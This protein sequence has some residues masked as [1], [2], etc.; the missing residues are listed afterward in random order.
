MD[1]KENLLEFFNCSL[2]NYVCEITITDNLL[3]KLCYLDNFCFNNK[4]EKLTLKLVETNEFKN[5]YRYLYVK[6][7]INKER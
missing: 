6:L 1:V 2:S 4:I 3:L 5:N 7:E